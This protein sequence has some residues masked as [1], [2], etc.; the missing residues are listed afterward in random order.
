M[1]SLFEVASRRVFQML[2][3]QLV[4]CAVIGKMGAVLVTIPYPVL[5]GAAII[6]FGLFLGIILSY[7]QF[8][9][10][11]SPRNLAVI[12]VAII[13]GL[14]VPNWIKSNFDTIKTGNSYLV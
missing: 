8:V 6:S 7:L 5:G 3:L 2:G 1:F 13:T 4:L 14:M 12:G 11:N 9:D 10:M